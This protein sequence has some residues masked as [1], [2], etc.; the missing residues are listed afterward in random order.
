MAKLFDGCAVLCDTLPLEI[1]R[2][3]AQKWLNIMAT[4]LWA[5]W[6]DG[7][8]IYGWE[9]GGEGGNCPDPANNNK[10]FL[11]YFSFVL[12]PSSSLVLFLLPRCTVARSF[13]NNGGY[14]NAPPTAL[15][16]PQLALL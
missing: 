3:V 14:K 1:V 11:L 10:Q 7:C 15:L 12:S 5:Q 8:G 16:F 2:I 13:G 4:Q 9:G 6:F